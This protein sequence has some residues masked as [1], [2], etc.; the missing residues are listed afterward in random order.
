MGSGPKGLYSPCKF[1][2]RHSKLLEMRC[3]HVTCYQSAYSRYCTECYYK[4]TESNNY[5]RATF[6]ALL[7]GPVRQINCCRCGINLIINQR[8]IDCI[9]CPSVYFILIRSLRI[10]GFE[11]N[12]IYGLLFDM[13]AK[14]VLRIVLTSDVDL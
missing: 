6:H 8:A 5:K 12:N 10:L 14:E 2:S 4:T 13:Q 11:P 9:N 3:L 7:A 1:F